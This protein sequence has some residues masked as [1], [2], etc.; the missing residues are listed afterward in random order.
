MNVHWVRAAERDRSDILDYIAA[1]DLSAA[2]RMD[3]LFS[4]AAINLTQFPFSGKAGS[5]AGTRE[6]I[7][8]ERYRLLYE[9]ADE[10]VWILALV[11]TA[12]RWP[13]VQC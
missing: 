6:L 4:Q 2:I 9:I 8:H 7:L 5:I 13:P 3:E 1:Q 11:H 12:Q 10:S